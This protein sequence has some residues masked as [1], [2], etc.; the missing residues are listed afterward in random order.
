MT[1]NLAM[2]RIG[3]AY[4]VTDRRLTNDIGITEEFSNKNILFAARDGIIAVGY[5]GVAFIDRVPTDQWLAEVLIG[6]RYERGAQPS[7]IRIGSIRSGYSV[8]DALPALRDALNAARPFVAPS[9]QAQWTA[10]SF[11]V[12]AVGWVW[13][14]A[15]YSVPVFAGIEKPAGSD[16]FVLG[17][18]RNEWW[19]DHTFTLIAAPDSTAWPDLLKAVQSGIAT[20]TTEL[21][22]EQALLAGV[23]TSADRHPSVGRDCMVIR[24]DPPD[25]ATAVV[26]F[27]RSGPPATEAVPIGYRVRKTLP[28]AYSP[29]IIGPEIIHAPSRMIGDSEVSLAAYRVTVRGGAPIGSVVGAL[30]PQRRRVPPHR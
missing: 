19:T 20:A 23:R 13:N 11:D 5:T 10:H 26:R 17:Y 4:L 22:V 27:D 30:S 25:S 16:E 7:G 15:G 24:I 6:E 14:A 2:P 18:L 1:L 8:Q 28:V 21:D 29:W 3:S 9:W 12:V